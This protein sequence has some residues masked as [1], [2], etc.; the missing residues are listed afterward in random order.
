MAAITILVAATGLVLGLRFNAFVLGL[1]LLRLGSF[2]WLQGAYFS[3][4]SRILRGV[5]GTQ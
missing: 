3:R 2:L 1:L 5:F 4:G